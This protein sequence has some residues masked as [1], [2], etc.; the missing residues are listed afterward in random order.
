MTRHASK[1]VPPI[2]SASASLTQGNADSQSRLQRYSRLLHRGAIITIFLSMALLIWSL[3]MRQLTQA[4]QSWGQTLGPWAIV[5]YAG[6]FVLLTMLSLPI[7]PLPFIAGAVFGLVEGTIVAAVTS[8]LAAAITFL[9]ARAVGR[10][11]LREYLESSPRMRAVEKTVQ[12]GNWKV[13]AAVR[14]SHLLPYGMQNYAFGLTTIS[15]WMYLGTTAIVTFPNILL[16]TWLGDLGFSS[17]DA[18]Q[19][20]SAADWQSWA[21]RI[22]G[23]IIVACAVGYIAWLAHSVYRSTVKEQFEKQLQEE[24]ASEEDGQR[25]PWG[26]LLLSLFALLLA[27]IA[28]VSAVRHEALRSFVEQRLSQSESSAIRPASSLSN[29]QLA[30]APLGHFP[31]QTPVLTDAVP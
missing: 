4:M 25:W 31:M 15:I 2:M 3:P 8:L 18:W 28:V 27:A 10:T 1:V 21:M 19:E 29:V 14:L 17:V 11:S 24:E 7:W 23:L 16:Q 9:I 22:G 6:V 12:V 30:T 20:R 5:V 13:V 26:T